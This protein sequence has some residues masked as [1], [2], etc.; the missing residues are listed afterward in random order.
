V[1]DADERGCSDDFAGLDSAVQGIQGEPGDAGGF[2][3]VG[4]IADV[5]G[6][7]GD[8]EQVLGVRRTY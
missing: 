4:G 8:E 2:V 1:E 5:V 3:D 6:S 7:V